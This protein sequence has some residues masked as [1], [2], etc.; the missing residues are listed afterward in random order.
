MKR[1]L[2]ALAGRFVWAGGIEDTFIP[3]ERP[4]LRSLEEYALTQ[5]YEQW[6][7][8]LKRAKS[9][10][11]SML[12][13]GVPWYRVEPSKGV[14]DWRWV[15]EVLAFMVNELGIKPI[16]DLVHY[17]TPDWMTL[18]FADPD[19]ARHVCQY[20]Q[21]F[22]K[23]YRHLV[24]YYTPLNEPTVNADFAARRGEWPPYLT[25]D[26]GYTRVLLNIARGIQETVRAISAVHPEAVF[27]AVEAMHLSRAQSY[28]AKRAARLA[29]HHD[30]LCWDL[31][32]GSVNSRHPL[33]K[34][35]LANNADREALRI[36]RRR[37]VQQDVLGVNFYPWSGQEFAVDEQGQA[38]NVNNK[39]S[40]SQIADMLRS[41]SAYTGA[42]LMVT[43]T[44][45]PGDI[46]VRRR[47]MRDTISGVTRVRNE[48]IPVLGYTWFPLFTMIGWEYRT[49]NEPIEKHLLHL[50]LW[51]CE[52]DSQGVLVRKETELAK[53]YRGFARRGFRAPA[54]SR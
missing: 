29:F 6:R 39:V 2:K 7:E 13:W 49:S 48:G 12:R 20:A 23:R 37:A 38:K 5:H 41:V 18:S 44:S 33:W 34:W 45:S 8:D 15:D 4:G 27:V 22:A 35:L 53:V 11:I 40:G 52:F 31:V 3:Q 43:E 1:G 32:K 17:G 26:E 21:A 54:F 10:G 42:P 30:L 19:Y 16:I 36:L 24:T 50:G 46:D 28:K 14:F 47:W 51:D 25:G 9:L